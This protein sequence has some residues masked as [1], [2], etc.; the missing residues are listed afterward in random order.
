MYIT[1]NLT[2]KIRN[3]TNYYKAESHNLLEDKAG[4]NVK[5]IDNWL[6]LADIYFRLFHKFSLGFVRPS[7]NGLS[8]APPQEVNKVLVMGK[9]TTGQKLLP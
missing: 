1:K 6:N 9:R 2:I 8:G 5:L 3:L 4:V 7:A